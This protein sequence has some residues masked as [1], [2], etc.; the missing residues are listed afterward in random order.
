MTG[1]H[2]AV[3]WWVVFSRWSSTE[4]EGILSR[5]L[6]VYLP[7]VLQLNVRSCPS[8]LRVNT[9]GLPGDRHKGKKV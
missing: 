6:V 9:R 7:K 4:L 1:A 3:L 2:D 8:S 5:L